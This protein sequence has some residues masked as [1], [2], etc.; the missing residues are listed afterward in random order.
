VPLARLTVVD[1]QATIPHNEIEP[2][3]NSLQMNLVT[4]ITPP[5]D[6]R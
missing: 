4:D 1:A 6:T 5:R 3:K 2:I